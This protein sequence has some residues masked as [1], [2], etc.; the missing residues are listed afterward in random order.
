[1]EKLK[2]NRILH[3]ESHDNDVFIIINDK[4]KVKVFFVPA[5]RIPDTQLCLLA[6]QEM[7]GCKA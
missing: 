4:L 6:L 1:M 2:T 7:D 5:T 3:D